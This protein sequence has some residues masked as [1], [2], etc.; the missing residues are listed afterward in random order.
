M[1]PVNV[2]TILQK[3][4]DSARE[5]A[6]RESFWR[7]LIRNAPLAAALFFA[8]VC[9]TV[10]YYWRSREGALR[11]ELQ[12]LADRVAVLEKKQPEILNSAREMIRPALR[13]L[14]GELDA[15]D[16]EIHDSLEILARQVEEQRSL[17]A[18]RELMSQK[19]SGEIVNTQ[20]NLHWTQNAVLSVAERLWQ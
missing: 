6:P 1:Q 15:R 18:Q 16:Q 11:T 9:A 7:K 14:A 12:Q 2:S 13:D 10:L 19:L 8:A 3:A 4:D 17:D 20:K 5:S